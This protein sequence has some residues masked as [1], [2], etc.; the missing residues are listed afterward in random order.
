MGL[1][2]KVQANTDTMKELLG[3]M[4]GSGGTT[5]TTN[6]GGSNNL[7][8]AGVK[9]FTSNV[10]EMTT[11]IGDFTGKL[12]RNNAQLPDVAGVFKTL[13]SQFG[14]IGSLIGDGVGGIVNYM[15]SSVK[16]WQAFSDSGLTMSGNA[17]KLNLAMSMTRLN[18]EDFGE[19]VKT[20]NGFALNLGRTVSEGVYHYAQFSDAFQSSGANTRLTQL[21]FTTKTTNDL[22]M[23]YARTR[24]DLDF[25]D[26]AVRERAIVEVE[27]LATKMA[28]TTAVT[29]ISR[30]KQVDAIKDQQ[31]DASFRARQVRAMRDGDSQ[32]LEA[33]QELQKQF[34]SFADNPFLMNA[35]KQS[36][37]NGGQ[38]EED[39]QNLL[40][41]T[42]PEFLQKLQSMGARFEN[43]SPEE[44]AR[45]IEEAKGLK[46]SYQQ[47]LA[48]GNASDF[49]ASRGIL[50]P[51][52]KKILFG[53][54]GALN[55]LIGKPA[56]ATAGYNK[57]D[58]SRERKATA[59]LENA[60][61]ATEDDELRNIKAGQREA[62]RETTVLVANTQQRLK[63]L[64]LVTNQ[65]IDKVNTELGMGVSG[66]RTMN[67][68]PMLTN[69]GVFK[70]MI[71]D[72]L[73]TTDFSKMSADEAKDYI[74]NLLEGAMTSISAKKTEGAEKK[75]GGGLFGPGFKL[76][77][78]L[79]PEL[80]KMQ[81]PGD[82]LTALDT[83]NLASDMK[84]GM[85]TVMPIL[86][87]IR[88]IPQTISNAVDSQS[89][90]STASTTSVGQDD[91][92]ELLK[93]ISNKMEQFVNVASQI[94]SYSEKTARNTDDLGDNV[95]S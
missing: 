43:G 84:N 71:A 60:G 48:T 14:G 42:M 37:G 86:N 67:L 8:T 12:V 17:M 44:R 78:E 64:S 6:V 66:I 81:N 55:E 95:Y 91:S 2:D 1:E 31:E 16:N 25:R 83:K 59:D 88:E 21:G 23:T 40:A 18:A 57:Y 7:T 32:F 79:G 61:F 51:E 34:G 35:V 22:L 53:A 39:T 5:P 9:L 13:S 38:L 63:D 33:S 45:I 65:F 87:M 24:S 30:Q 46:G 90:E 74:M 92:T 76:V 50:T 41:K 85:S 4:K 52:E 89:N 19:A 27:K 49:A 73:G 77:G 70:A 36:F 94:A 20:M 11:A 56:L 72:K 62:G 80:V 69:G 15:D 3:L 29:G 47:E 75:A 58:A 54:Y 28:E 10:T 82:M 68:Q 93:Q 26:A